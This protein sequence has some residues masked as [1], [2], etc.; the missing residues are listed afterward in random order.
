MTGLRSGAVA[1]A[2]GVNAQTLRYYERRGL[3]GSPHRSPGGHRRYP[4]ETVILLRVVKAAQRLGFSLDE[5]AEL[6]G[7]GRPRRPGTADVRSRAAAKLAE[8][9]GR[10]ADLRV[11]AG[12]LR[13]AV[14]AG[15]TDLVACATS[16]E[17]PIPF[18]DPSARG[19]VGGRHAGPVSVGRR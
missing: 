2:A 5:V 17:C 10:I 9:E 13:A 11:V 12:T 16:V 19:Q 1:A 6:L 14:E 8:V 4:P 3:L 18:D 15:C 7:V